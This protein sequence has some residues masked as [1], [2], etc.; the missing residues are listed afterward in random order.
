MISYVLKIEHAE[1]FLYLNDEHS[2][3]TTISELVSR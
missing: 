3:K 2:L 1:H